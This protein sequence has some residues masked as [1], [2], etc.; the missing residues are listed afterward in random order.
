MISNSLFFFS[1]V[2]W[3]QCRRRCLHT[4]HTKPHFPTIKN[5]FWLRISGEM[6][7]IAMDS[8]FAFGRSVLSVCGALECMLPPCVCVFVCSSSWILCAYFTPS[9]CERCQRKKKRENS[10]L[11]FINCSARKKE[12]QQRARARFKHKHMTW[13][14]TKRK[15]HT[16][17]LSHWRR[18]Q[19]TDHMH[20][21]RRQ[22]PFICFD[23]KMR[24]AAVAA[25]AFTSFVRHEKWKIAHRFAKSFV[26][27]FCVLGALLMIVICS[28]VP[29]TGT[30]DTIDASTL[31]FP[32]SMRHTEFGACSITVHDNRRRYTH[33]I[34]NWNYGE[35][36][37][38]FP[39]MHLRHRIA[40]H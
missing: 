15:S 25:A 37:T 12:P 20:A 31:F 7:L 14:I 35:Y 23:K 4:S 28:N 11:N 38:H 19:T 5:S 10:T 6:K 21:V 33:S 22:F 16:Q 26:L 2:E 27:W 8:P 40:M 36:N 29:S 39:L 1:H 24:V 30:F 32:A 13:H 18:R 34:A 17:R 3:D 9:N